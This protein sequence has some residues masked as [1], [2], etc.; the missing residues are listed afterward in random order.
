MQQK[1]DEKP[2]DNIESNRD[3]N[4]QHTGREHATRTHEFKSQTEQNDFVDNILSD[5]YSD[6]ERTL[7]RTST[8]GRKNKDE[9]SKLLHSNQSGF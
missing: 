5:V 2:F 1:N 4:K 7:E 8:R 3:W 9:K 6:F